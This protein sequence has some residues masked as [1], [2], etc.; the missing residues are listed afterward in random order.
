MI[1]LV[2][3]YVPPSAELLG[4]MTPSCQ[5][6]TRDHPSFQTRLTPLPTSVVNTDIVILLLLTVNSLG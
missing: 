3:R 6:Q 2:L 5:T 1:P 4:P